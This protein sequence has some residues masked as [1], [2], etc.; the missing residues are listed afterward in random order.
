MQTGVIYVVMRDVYELYTPLVSF[1]PL[2]AC[3]ATL[4]TH[5]SINLNTSVK[6]KKKQQQTF[7]HPKYSYCSS[8]EEGVF[9][10][11]NILQYI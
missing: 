6:Y 1:K 10:N 2:Q 3:L 8:K 7:C 9:Y 11:K 4:H 5:N